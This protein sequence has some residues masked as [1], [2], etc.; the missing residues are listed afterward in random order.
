MK[1]PL[2]IAWRYF[3]SKEKLKVINI[4]SLVSL[5]GIVITT[6]ALLVVLSVFNGF[7]FVG[8]KILSYSNAPLVIEASKG[9]VF[10]L[11]SIPFDKVK[12]LGKIEVAT[13]ILKENALVSFKDNYVLVQMKGIEEDYVRIGRIDTSM[14]EGSFLLKKFDYDAGVLGLGLTKS[15]SLGMNADIVGAL[16]SVVVP[17]RDAKVSIVEQDMFYTKKLVYAGSFQMNASID[18]TDMLVPLDFARQILDYSNNEV[19]AVLLR[20]KNERDIPKLK[21]QIQDMLGKDFSVK[22][23]LEQ[24]PIYNKVVKAE[25]FGVYVILAFIIF[26]ATFNVMGSLSLLIMDKKKDILILHSMGATLS[27]IRWIYF[28]NGLI[29]SLIGATIGLIIGLAICL[30]QQ[31]FGVIKMGNGE[32]VV[33]A[34]PVQIKI[35][36]IFYVFLLV[37]SIGALSIALMVSRIKF[38]NKKQ[39]D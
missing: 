21:A 16:L 2:F 38:E 23:I 39:V 5:I 20:A 15:L 37:L 27:S 12:A 30:L 25:R 6:S 4:I 34:F 31:H 33:D 7:T 10:S 11:D 9:K 28:L 1:L 17:K 29:L 8:T 22:D 26:I 36:D 32:F 3:F 18:Q 14:V 19:S 35:M 13:P 24:D